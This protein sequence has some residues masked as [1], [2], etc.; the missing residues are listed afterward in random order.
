MKE[1]DIS[2]YVLNAFL[3]KVNAFGKEN[4]TDIFTIDELELIAEEVERTLKV[5]IKKKKECK[6]DY[7]TQQA[8]KRGF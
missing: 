4:K 1:K 6:M 7:Q 2:N 3:R 5:K 8:A